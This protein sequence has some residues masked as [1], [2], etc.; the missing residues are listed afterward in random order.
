MGAN[1]LDAVGNLPLQR[2]DGPAL[3]ILMSQQRLAFGPALYPL[4][5]GTGEVPARLTGGLGGIEVNMRLDKGGHRHPLL[6]IQ[7]PGR[8][9]DLAHGGYGPDQAIL[10]QDLPQPLPA[11]QTHIL[12]QHVPFPFETLVA[13]ANPQLSSDQFNRKAFTQNAYGAD[14]IEE[15][16]G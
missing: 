11:T 4:E 6:P 7:F 2:L 10:T 14:I 13:F 3:H 5:Q 15:Q 16:Q 1:E 9:E 8:E 12:Y